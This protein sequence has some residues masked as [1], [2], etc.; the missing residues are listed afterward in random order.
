MA[1]IVLAF[2]A[3]ENRAE[4][5]PPPFEITMTCLF[6]VRY[7]GYCHRWATDLMLMFSELVHMLNDTQLMGCGGGVL[8]GGDLN[9][10]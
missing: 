10:L 9:V 8:G 7:T 5:S 6:G 3:T 2:R 1:T 4:N